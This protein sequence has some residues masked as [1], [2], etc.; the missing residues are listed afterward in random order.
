MFK[1]FK[2]LQKMLLVAALCVPWVTQAQGDCTPISTFPVTYGF[3]ASEGFTTTVTAAAACTTNVFSSCWRNEETTFN[4]SSSTGSG[5]IWHIYGGTS[6]TFLHSGAHSLMLPDKG[7]STAGVST[8]MLT[9][10][11]MNFT[12]PV[13]YIVTF[14][15]QR[16][17][18][19][20]SN[21]EGF[22]IYASPTDTIGP[23]AV[24]LGHYSRH[25]TLAYPC[26]EPANGW[27]QYETSPITLTGTVYIIFEGQS[28]YGSSTY[29]DDVV[30]METPSCFK[31]SNLAIDAQQTTT[32]SFTLTWTDTSNTGA[33]YNI[34]RFTATDT[35]LVQDG[36]TGTSYTVSG[37]NPATSYTFAVVT[38]CGNGDTSM[39][40]A[41]VSAFT[42]CAD[43]AAA[44]LPYTEDFED[45]TSGSANPINPCW[46]K[47]TNNTT[48]YPYPNSTAAINSSIGLHFYGYYPSSATSTH[49][50][51]W[52]A[53]PPIDAN[54]D[55]SDL[56]LTLD[57][58]R[59]STV[60]NYYTTIL[61]VGVADSVTG[62][63]SAAAIESS[64]TWIDTI[65][66]TSA[67]ASSIHNL[68]VSFADYAGNGKYVF[69]YAPTPELVGTS[70]YRYNYVYVDNVALR[71]I[72][73][74]FWPSD[75]VVTSVSTDETTISWTP[76]PRTA[77]PSS[78]SIEY[79]ET[80]FTPGEGS[81]ETSYTNSVTLGNLTANTE[82][83]VYIKANCGGEMSDATLFSFRTLC[84]ALDS[85]P[86][87]MDFEGYPTTTST[88]TDF[89]PCLTRLNNG[90]Q[91]FGYP[92]LASTAS[93]CHSG[94]RGLYWTNSTTTGTYGDYQ[95]VIMPAVDT[96]QYNM[97]TLQFKFWARAT[98][99]SYHPVFQVGVM[100]NPQDVNSFQLVESVDVE[101]TTYE[102]YTVALGN[103][104]GYGNYIALRALR[105]SSTWYATV[106]DLTIEEMPNCPNVVDLEAT[107]TVGN[108]LL[109]WD[110]Q[111]GYEAPTG[112]TIV[113]D[114]IGGS[115]PTTVTSTDPTY[116]IT[117]LEAA[118]A[119]KAYVTADCNGYADS[120]EFTTAQLDCIELDLT[121][122]DTVQFSNSTTGQSGCI[123]YSSWGNTAYQT[124]YTA[125]ELTTAG[126]TAGNIIGIDLG[127]TSSTYAKEFTIFIGTTTTSSISDATLENPNN[128]SQVYGPAAHP[129]GTTG[130]QHYDFTTPFYWDGV[131]NII[132]TTFMN[133]PT[134]VSQTSSSGLTGYYE[135]A[136]NKARF[137]YQ[138][139]Q[140]FTLSNY[141]GGST[142][143]TYSYRAAI[144]FY[145]GDCQTLA[146]C[147]APTATATYIGTDTVIVSWIP[148]YNETAWDVA[149]REA[150]A[151]T[152]TTV[153]TGVSVNEYVFDSLTPGTD[154]E[155]RISFECDDDNTTV[156]S[157][158]VEAST[159]CVPVTLPYTENFDDVTTSTSTTNYGLMPNCWNY[160]MT[161]TSTYQT[162][163]YLPRVYYST[164]TNY[165]HSG[166]YCLYLYGVG[167]FELPE[168]PTTLDSLMI[169]FY[170]YVSSS[171]YGLIV[172]AMED[173]VFVPIDTATLVSSTPNFVE[174]NL[175]RYHGTSRKIALRNYYTTS[176][177]TYTSYNYIDNIYVDYIPSCPHVVNLAVDSVSQNSVSLSWTAAGTESTWSVTDGTNYYTT[178]VP[179][180]TIGNL[181]VNTAYTFS[182]RA[183]CDDSDSSILWTVDARTSCEPYMSLPY[184]ENFDNHTTSTTSV[185]NV[186]IPC[187]GRVMTGTSSYQTGSYLPMVYYYSNTSS[188]IYTHSGN[189]SLRLYGVGYHT[190][191]QLPCPADS[192]TI[193]FWAKTS[194]SSY[195]LFFGVMSDPTD[196]STFDTIQAITYATTTAAANFQYFEFN[197]SN[198]TGTGRYLAFRNSYTSASTYYSYHYI[199]DIEVWHN[200]NCPSPVVSLGNVTNN[201]IDVS[202]LDTTGNSYTNGVT[203]MW[204]TVN[205]TSGAQTAA[206][207]TGNNYTITGLNGS[208]TYY[209]WIAGNCANELSRP[210][211]LVATTASD[212]GEVENL[213]LAGVSDN[214]LGISWN[215]P[216][217]G[218]PATSY[219]V[220]LKKCTNI[221]F[222]NDFVVVRDTVNATYY[223]FNGLEDA[224]TYAYSVTTVC[225]DEVGEANSGYATTTI[226]EMDTV[227]D[228]ATNYSAQPIYASQAYSYTQQ[229]YM[230]NELAGIDSINSIAIY[231]RGLWG[232]YED[233]NVTVYLGH[234]NKTEFESTADYVPMSN[235]T[236]VYS[237]RL[238]GFGWISLK[239]DTT[240]VRVADSNLVV[241]IDD[242]TG[243]AHTGNCY[244]ACSK[245]DNP[246]IYRAM[247]MY[248]SSNIQPTSPSGTYARDYYRAFIVFGNAGCENDGCDV[249]VVM[250]SAAYADH[251][252][253]TWNAAQ[254]AS[255]DVSYRALGTDNWITAATAVTGGIASINGLGA[256]FLGEAR[257]SYSCNGQIVSGTTQIQTLCGPASLPLAE[258]FQSC[259]YGR[260]SR[261]CWITGL[262][263]PASADRDY[264]YVTALT[265]NENNMLCFMRY[266]AYVILPQIDT[267]L[268]ECQ[269][270]FKLTQGND[271]AQILLGV[272]NDASMPIHTMYV[273]DTLSRIDYDATSSTASITY[274]LAN[275][276]AAYSHGRIAFWDAMSSYSFI[277][278]IVVELIPSCTPAS[279]ITA[280]ASTN[281][282]TV[283]WTTDGDN[284]S[285][286][287]IVYGPRGF[288]AGQGDTITA[289]G[290]PVTITGLN[291]STNYDAYVYTV[292]DLL[293]A[294]SSASNVVQFTTDCAPYNTLPYVMNFENLLPAGSS[295]ATVLPNC[296]ASETGTNAVAHVVYTTNSTQASSPQHAFYMNENGVVAL[297]EMGVALNTLKL[298]FHECNLN[299]QTNGLVVGTVANVNT[300]FAQ[301]FVPYDTIVFTGNQSIY[302]VTT[303]MVDYTGTATRLALKNYSTNGGSVSEH[304]IDDLTIE[305]APAC[306]PIQ[307][308]R[309]TYLVGDEITLE[310]MRSNSLAYSVEYGA[311][312]FTLGNGTQTTTTTRN[313]SLTGLTPQTQYDVYVMS[314]C[315]TV[316]YTFTTPCT[317]VSLP[318]TENF[319][320]YT[321]STTAATGYQINCWDY[322]MTGTSTYQTATYQPQI[323]YGSTNAN[324]GSYSLRLYGESYTM[325]PPM[326]TT[327]DS[328]QLTFWDYTTSASY[329]LE[330]GV[331]EGNTFIP[332]Q[333][334]NS[335]TSTHVEYE[336]SLSSYHGN[337]RIIAFRNKYTT[338]T[339]IYYSYHY[340][341]DIEVDYIPSCPKV[342]DLTTTAISQNSVT[343]GW[344]NGGSETQ[345]IVEYGNNSDV[346]NSNPYTVTGLTPNTE[347]TFNVRPLCGVGDTGRARTITVTTLCNAVSLP[348]T[349]NFDSYTTSTTAATGV[350]PNCWSYVMTGTNTTGSYLPQ[351]YYS[352]T[353]ANSG[354]YSLRLY[355]LCYF[356]LPEMDAPIDSLQISFNTYKTSAAYELEVGVMEGNTFVPIQAIDYGTSTHSQQTVYLA[357]YTGTGNRIAFR[358]NHSSYQY[359]YHYI[360]DIVVDY[361]PSCMPVHD[362]HSTGA[363]IS[364]IDVDWTD[365]SSATEW[366]VVYGTAG[367]NMSQGTPMTVYSHPITLSNLDSATNYDV[368]VRPICSVGDTGSWTMETLMSG[369]CDGMVEF[370]TGSSTGTSNAIPVDNYY[371][372]TLSQTIIDSAELAQLNGGNGSPIN[373]T[374]IAYHYNYTT[375]SAEKTD[376]DIWIQ[377][378][379]KSTFSSTTDAVALNTA[380]AVKVYHGALN[381]SQGW[382]YFMFPDTASY[383]WDGHSNL[384]VIV[385]DNSGEY[386]GSS[387]VFSTT[388][389][390]G[391]KTLVYYSDSDNPNVNTPS[392]FSG[393]KY[394]YSY[395]PTMKL[396]SCGNAICSKPQVLPASNVTYNSATINWNSNSATSFEVAVKVATD[397]IW[398]AE[399]AVNNASSYDVTNLT[400]ATTY[401]FRVRAICDPTENLI[402]DWAIGT[403]TTDSLPCFTP[404]DLHTTAVGYTSVNLAWSA[405]SEQ[406]HWT[407]TVWNTA[408]SVDYD[409]TGNAAYTVIGLTQDNQY[410]AAVKA[411]CGNGIAESEYSDTIQFTTNNCE[412]VAGVTVTNITENSAVVNWEP[413][414]ANSYEVDYGPVGHGQGQGSTVTV[415]GVTT[416]TITGLESE[417]GYSVYV[418]ALCEAD[419]PGP[420]SQ[421]QE[422]TTGGIGIDVADGMNV[423]IYPN[424]TSSTTTIALSGVNGDVAI[425]VVD[426]NGRVVMS[427]S[428]SCEGDCVKTMEVSGLAQGAYFVRINGENV[429]MVK[430]LVVK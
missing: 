230:S 84:N 153:A 294:T 420:W 143:S 386:D 355:G 210:M 12:N 370:F 212:C 289:T 71:V 4:G 11:A 208:T 430:K 229:L 372:Y 359:S 257:V 127:F 121:S 152:W 170:D 24:E 233:R 349:E 413:A 341:D 38:D 365:L 6:A 146:T 260:F 354:S 112:Y 196:E 396:I 255:Y 94:T 173:G 317:A 228:Y 207:A 32:N 198:Y 68:E 73:T 306:I 350:L 64:I 72:P 204:N 268:S 219:I 5:R 57:V 402:S 166:N 322:I 273:L 367:F 193:G 60:S 345:W 291:H 8:T 114:S 129:T 191:P 259:D 87:T 266:G 222:A 363:T 125:A 28:Y 105:P 256:S 234:T 379:T 37:L 172:G 292:C 48:A 29:I 235:L 1:L 179:S 358:N 340:I 348:F 390:T 80:G 428:M 176:T 17:G 344:T 274:S 326:P 246:A 49:Y 310:W 313:V 157:T 387:Y 215:A 39:Y 405:S 46:T 296:W 186:E 65:D 407:L 277:D 175:N 144:H 275:V 373:F 79:G 95:Y 111:S 133:Q 82:Y 276:P 368:Y 31:V 425:T 297:P 195:K 262:T 200:S 19:G 272:I 97:N 67:T 422:F 225:N 41:T 50:Y 247:R 319:D 183:L 293:N 98:G 399:V 238:S 391:N 217:I 85:L 135:S 199:D 417:T 242:N 177:T 75:A 299:P 301:T 40:S 253:I 232:E 318:Y 107:A 104:E 264:P 15:I 197:L 138:D 77:N 404:T 330:V 3:E 331:M 128:H 150:S 149:Y 136:S 62:L 223:M 254:G 312:G 63:S 22:K 139:S 69:L 285:S 267:A 23:G 102:E 227:G 9:F 397:A 261:P 323:Y 33:T 44:D 160:T 389:C 134:G 155:F 418:R 333:T 378:T 220:T 304:Y 154:Y 295:I 131:S 185:T 83:D 288:T 324:S 327:L 187:W 66:L 7:S 113:Y 226:C 89:V 362:I 10:P 180:I 332:I 123:A 278:D 334:I 182:V 117:G 245:F 25:R 369:I 346:A 320:S 99:T 325:L 56:M 203:V 171:S 181:T 124:I 248:S 271:D 423:S 303:Y 103:F 209:I 101:G 328:L 409:V 148:G 106:D 339:T 316:F 258:D 366:E 108:A 34:Y 280:T 14:W 137:R 55:M 184:S 377:P 252:D 398:P 403:F 401:Q 188:A 221:P 290:S 269:I 429:N 308:L 419:A 158:T 214:T 202:W 265:G 414:T 343:L 21:P 393:N 364:S 36:V 122:L 249:P 100:S 174:F 298:S 141:N 90:T 307:N 74:C 16:N 302:D 86:Y 361:V 205:S 314:D 42:A 415:D 241:V 45:Y 132:I 240:Y 47:G 35:T 347:Y 70:T 216:S 147:A 388:A 381:C 18:T 163:S 284:A 351:I 53:L 165:V 383:N 263:N 145:S 51:S 305:L 394:I 27:Y 400:P 337:S 118:T 287:F 270:R 410:Y 81:T 426:M 13:G 159:Q 380:T 236:Q 20:T 126:L 130:W 93:Y 353:Y 281:T 52:A 213:T 116:A 360:D 282:A 59:Y 416:Y 283:S 371:N 189:Y 315:D 385:D 30:I 194:S 300:G 352:S 421:V 251:V 279:E 190:L 78:W 338:S 237:G 411:I 2:F 286:Y 406:N 96:D 178:T 58:K 311:H 156:Y 43:I 374:G 142:G 206:V 321:T 26:I 211:P 392:T 244:W 61:W 151:S 375:A 76:D 309:A 336:I 162:G 384:L 335:P 424:P 201:T 395:R 110:Y 231:Q 218:D 342:R 54:L 412:Q 427:D 140:Q 243:V 382:N 169:S 92:Y 192:V 109:T 164:S 356:I 120:V 408:G 329:G 168:M 91:Y 250:Q 161:G 167:I 115:N 119:Y 357:S 239:F 224:T 376:V 88:S